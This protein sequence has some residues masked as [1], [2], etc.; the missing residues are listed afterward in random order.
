MYELV[1]AEPILATIAAA[2]SIAQG[3]S[4]IYNVLTGASERRNYFILT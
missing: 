3:V 4:S 1:Y 2:G